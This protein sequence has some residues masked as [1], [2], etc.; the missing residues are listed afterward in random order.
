MKIH[1]AILYQN[2]EDNKIEDKNIKSKEWRKKNKD[3]VRGYDKEYRE[4]A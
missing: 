2:I 3:K 4:N 1:T